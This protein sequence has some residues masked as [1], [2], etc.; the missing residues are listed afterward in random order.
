ML[1][2]D[3]GTLTTTGSITLANPV[4]ASS[5]ATTS[6]IYVGMSAD[7]TLNGDIEGSGTIERTGGG[8]LALGGDN[9]GFWGTFSNGE[10]DLSLSSAD[11]GSSHAFWI[12]DD[13]ELVSEVSGAAT[14]QLG[15]LSGSGHLTNGATGTVTLEVGDNDHSTTFSGSIEDGSGSSIVALTKTGR[16]TLVLSG[17]NTYTGA[18][19]IDGLRT[20]GG[21]LPPQGALQAET[22]DA[23]PDYDNVVVN[24]AG[25]LAV[26]VGGAGEWSE[27]DVHSL[28]SAATFH[29]GSWLAI[30]TSDATAG[31]TYGYSITGAMGL[32]KLGAG[33]LTLTATNT[34]TGLTTVEVSTSSQGNLC[35]ASGA[36]IA[37]LVFVYNRG[38]LSGSGEVGEVFLLVG[39]SISPGDDGGAAVGT[40]TINGNFH[41]TPGAHYY[42]QLSDD[43]P[44]CDTINVLGT[45][46]PFYAELDLSG[47]RT[48][49]IDEALTLILNDGPDSILNPFNFP[50]NGNTVT[51]GGVSYLADYAHDGNDLALVTLPPP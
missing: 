44:S 1:H 49:H 37:S 11:S 10:G 24:D 9:S 13:S 8:T 34:Y 43:S 45:V 19:T 42:A 26:N 7:L 16:G 35:V 27:A 23:I 40:L 31:F 6:Q 32:R 28:L 15:S 14:I 22:P 39:G 30:D 21:L 50:R 47:G 46:D 41:G 20:A 51:V 5:C 33:T 29:N 25:T 12:V 18:T 38:T 48:R 36:S 4:D 17:V 3:G 2:F